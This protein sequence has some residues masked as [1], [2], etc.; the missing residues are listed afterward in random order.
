MGNPP[1]VYRLQQADPCL[2][3]DDANHAVMYLR[4]PSHHRNITAILQHP[5][6]IAAFFQRAPRCPQFFQNFLSL[7]LVSVEKICIFYVKVKVYP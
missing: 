4:M 3:L 6:M 1:L 2:A 7:R 5:G